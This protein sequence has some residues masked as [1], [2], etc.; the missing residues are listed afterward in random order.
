MSRINTGVNMTKCKLDGCEREAKSLGMCGAHYMRYRR[1]G[2]EDPSPIAKNTDYIEFLKEVALVKTDEC[3]LWPFGRYE[4][5]YG[6][7]SVKKKA[8]IA[9]RE[10]CKIAHGN[11]KT[12][13][14]VAAHNCGN[15]PCINPRHLRWATQHENMQDKKIHGTEAEGPDHH[16]SKLNRVQVIAIRNSKLS[17]SQLSKIYG[18]SISNISNIKNFKSYKN[19]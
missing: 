18:I 19:V 3:I 8:K 17:L 9:S 15:P 5:G 7:F 4:T 1:H 13:N 2:V 11:P 16:N 12:D 10:M 6:R 14:L